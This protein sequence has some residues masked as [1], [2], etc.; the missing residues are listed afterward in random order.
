MRS[1]LPIMGQVKATP[2]YSKS[3]SWI[4]APAP[5]RQYLSNDNC[6]DDKKADYKN[7]GLCVTVG[8]SDTQKHMSSS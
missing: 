1:C 6:P 5:S 4:T 3:W 8:Y 2:V 7:V